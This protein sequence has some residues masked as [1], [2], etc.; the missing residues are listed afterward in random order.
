MTLE[1]TLPIDSPATTAA[2]PDP[3]ADRLGVRALFGDV[4]LHPMAAM[5][6]LAA[7]ADA[8]RRWLVPLAIYAVVSVGV[9][10]ASLPAQQRITKA[11]SVAQIERMQQDNPAMS[12]NIN[13]QQVSS[14]S[15]NPAIIAISVIFGILRILVVV[16]A[17]AFLSAA[18]LHFLGTILGGQQSF[19]QV[20]VTI[21]WAHVPL[22][23]RGLLQL[24]AAL[25]GNF[26]LNSDGLAGLVAANKLLDPGAH[27]SYLGPILGQIELW[28][29]WSLGLIAVAV[30]CVCRLSRAKAIMVVA[31]LVL[32]AILLGEAGVAI[33]NLTA[34]I[35]SAATD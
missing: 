16:F 4:I 7:H 2:A 1:S 35:S 30:Y 25:M 26:D 3:G 13:A 11:M 24:V 6:R 22:I 10:F 18:V 14:I 23:L 9:L 31:V 29:L 17:G 15:D 27:S 28:N 12:S 8:K 32:L 20:L 34:G 21:A 5:Q 19:T 33:A